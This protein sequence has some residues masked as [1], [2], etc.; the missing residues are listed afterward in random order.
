MFQKTLLKIVPDCID[1]AHFAGGFT[2]HLSV[3]QAPGKQ[4]HELC[5]R[6]QVGWKPVAFILAHIYLIWRNDPPKDV[7]V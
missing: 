7:F 2:P 6:W 4:A 5:S 1:V 3:G